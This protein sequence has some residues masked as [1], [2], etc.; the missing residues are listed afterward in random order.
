MAEFTISIADPQ[1]KNSFKYQVKEQ[2]A[3]SL[4]GLKLGAIVE[5]AAIGLNGYEFE[6][7]GGSDNCGFPLRA[8][9]NLPRKRVV[10]RG[11]VG[12]ATLVA[13]GYRKRKTVCGHTINDT[14]KQINLVMVKGENIA[15]VL[16]TVAKPAKEGA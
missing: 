11:G 9:I 14:T 10:M 2:Q 6:I 13:K 4:L 12:L 1:A 15:S 5:G 3:D 8:G 7:T 16:G